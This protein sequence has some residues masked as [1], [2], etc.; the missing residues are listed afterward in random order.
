MADKK[1]DSNKPGGKSPQS[2]RAEKSYFAV[3]RK[4]RN[5]RLMFII[6][7]A[8][9]LIAVGAYSISVYSS[10]LTHNNAAY[11]VLGSAHVHAAFAVK[12]N[13]TKLDFSES[14][15]QVKSRF[16]HVE[17]EDGDTLH[18]H[19]TGVPVAEFFRS[20]KMNVTDTCFTDDNGTQYCSNGKENLEFY[21]NGNKTNSIADY[22]FDDDDRILVV[23]GDS[24]IQV[25]QDLD[26]LQQ[27]PIQK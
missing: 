18:R 27:T 4:K 17:N 8:A 21:V 9:V 7:A 23:Y 22:V 5:R 14:K 3:S 13:G 24:P 10:N 16:M 6:P 19:A 25:K 12:L 1:K 11:G 15:Y 20:I 2:K 26:Q